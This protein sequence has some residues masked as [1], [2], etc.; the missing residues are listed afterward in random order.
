[1]HEMSYFFL[2]NLARWAENLQTKTC[3]T[4]IGFEA[5]TTV[6][7]KR[8]LCWNI[9]PFHLLRFKWRYGEKCR[10]HLQGRRMSQAKNQHEAGS[11]ICLYFLPDSCCI[12]ARLNLIFWKCWWYI[13]PKRHFTFNGLRGVEDRTPFVTRA[14]KTCYLLSVFLCM[15]RLRGRGSSPGRVKNFHFSMLSRPALWSTQPPIQ[16]VPGALSRG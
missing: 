12:L 4:H 2:S 5:L 14:F 1:M 11:K 8:S 16:W 7:M 10:L 3:N 15:I 13:S 9:T 6:I